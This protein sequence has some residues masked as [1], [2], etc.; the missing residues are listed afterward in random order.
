MIKKSNR[1]Q[2]SEFFSNNKR[3]EFFKD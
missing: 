3:Q 1:R 2:W